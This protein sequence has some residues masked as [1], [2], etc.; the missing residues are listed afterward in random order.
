MWSDRMSIE[1]Q[2]VPRFQWDMLDT[3]L[4]GRSAI[5]VPRLF[6]G[7]LRDA[8]AFLA[9][10]GFDWDQAHH[11]REVEQLRQE[12]I[13][14]L[15]EELLT[16]EPGL[17]L[18]DEIRAET[19]VRRLLLWASADPTGA[20]QRW[21]CV[22]LRLM[23]T[24]AHVGSW[25]QEQYEEA[26]LAQIRERFDRHVHRSEDGFVLGQLGEAI[27]LHTYEVRGRKSRRSTA[28]KLL[29]K[30]ENVGTDV[31]DFVGVRLVTHNRFDAL[32]VTR[33]IRVH[34]IIMFAHVKPGRS[35]NTLVDLAAVREDLAIVDDEIR[36]GK[37]A[38]YERLSAMRE[39]TAARGYPG[40]PTPSYN[41]YSSATYHSI[42][43][44]CSQQIRV[45]NPHLH[46]LRRYLRDDRR[47]AF[48]NTMLERLG[49]SGETRFFFPFE[50]QI[51]DRDSWERSRSGRAS[52]EEYKRRQRVAVKQRLL[53][54]MLTRVPQAAP[55]EPVP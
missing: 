16:D 3:I 19:D 42:Q 13:A 12:A 17:Y 47:V 7:D 26:I 11:Q 10:Y 27:R 48:V 33:F 24:F 29:Q 45:K 18:P 14:F 40:G 54:D 30:A 35:R 8:H 34:N 36:A 53:G 4:S 46:M 37:L 9:C 6:V 5:D 52:H 22:L 41:P 21:S 31:F 55:S 51:M 28:M 25:F 15:E 1:R 32:L 44:T 39:R 2:D 20:R 38:E 43:F 49:I 23:H 50:V